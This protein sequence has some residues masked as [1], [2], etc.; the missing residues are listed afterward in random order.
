[1]PTQSEA[2]R[3]NLEYYKKRAKALLHRAK[4]GDAGAIAQMEGKVALHAAQRAVAREQGFASWPRF[5]AFLEQS[6]LDFQGLVAAFV[7]AALSDRTRAEELLAAQ[8]SIAGAGLYPALV[9]GEREQV[10]STVGKLGV[11]TPGGPRD[12][13]PILYCCFSRFANPASGRADA[14]VETVRMLLARGAD[15]NASFLAKEWPDN[16]FPA[17][18]GATG[19][20]NNPTLGRVLLEA[21][22]KADDSESL[23]HSTE[24]HG[25]YACAKLL[26]EFG[27]PA[28]QAL[29]HMLDA[30]TTVGVKLLL[31][32]GAD[33]NRVNHRGETALH[34]A[35]WRQRSAEVIAA[36]LDHGAAI[37][38]RRPDGLTAYAL[39]VLSGQADVA[40]LLASRGADTTVPQLVRSPDIDRLLPDMASV[41]SVEAVQKLLA[42]GVPIDTRGEHGATAL[43]W[44]C[45][46]GYPDLV[47][48][49]LAHGAPL[50]VK[51]SSFN[52][53][54]P[55]WF[56]HGRE[57]NGDR[58]G[59]DYPAVA[60]ALRAA[61]CEVT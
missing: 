48:L 45:W 43:H 54:P 27:A 53:D 42:A 3:L 13:A 2:S 31:D 9:L 46:K 58:R 40:A 33:V 15:P 34:W 10:E 39:A 59:S 11:S 56:D 60:E 50:D 18:Y 61:G 5:R 16:P 55:G 20:N 37:D 19:V 52:A 51:D 17:L 32:A 30:E 57:N 21:G 26:L 6:K 35:V 29:N 23:Y 22:A 41:H 25:D 12:R 49:L 1:M 47:R 8:P 38:A 28:T 36:I 24:H 14:L 4:A 44:A 7:E